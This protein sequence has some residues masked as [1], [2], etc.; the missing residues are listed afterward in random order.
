VQFL[1]AH[2]DFDLPLHESGHDLDPLYVAPVERALDTCRNSPDDDRGREIE[3]APDEWLKYAVSGGGPY[4]IRLPDAAIDAPLEYEWHK[5]TFVNYLRICFRW[6]GF[7]GLE[8]RIHRPDRELAYLT[9][10][11]LPI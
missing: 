9:E 4:T 2:P 11:L 1:A 3:I 6:G 7:P 5:T 8:S 10:G